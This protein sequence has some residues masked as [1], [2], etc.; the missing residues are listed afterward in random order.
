VNSW[1]LKPY[2]SFLADGLLAVQERGKAKPGDKTLV[3]VLTPVASRAAE[4]A[5]QP[6]DESLA[7]LVA[8]AEQAVEDTRHMVATV[9]KAKTLESV[10]RLSGPGSDLDAFYH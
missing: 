6:L 9:G 10:P 2:R 3:D 4:M 5:S 7:V 8:V 1:I